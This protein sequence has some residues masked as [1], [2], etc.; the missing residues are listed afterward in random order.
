MLDVG[1]WPVALRCTPDIVPCIAATQALRLPNALSG[2]P[3]YPLAM[4]LYDVTTGKELLRRRT[5]EVIQEDGRLAF[6]SVSPVYTLPDAIQTTDVSFEEASD[7]LIR[8]GGYVLAQS[9]DA[10]DLTLFWQPITGIPA[11]FVRFVH[12]I[13]ASGS[14]VAQVDSHPAANSYPTGQWISSEVV[15]DSIRL[16]LS[17]VPPGEYRLATGFYRPV[18]GLPR[19]EAVGPD[20]PLPDGRAL[21]S[22]TITIPTP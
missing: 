22:E 20:G 18:E 15:T 14:V 21:L 11:D 19:L 1:V 17:A 9:A 6:R 10:V 2:P 12:L 8:L 13:D 5:G 3:P 7:P 16:D 4:I